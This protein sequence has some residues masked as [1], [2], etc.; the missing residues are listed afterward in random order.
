MVKKF[1]HLT[2]GRCHIIIVARNRSAAERILAALEIP[3][4]VPHSFT[5]EFVSCDASLIQNC[6]DTSKYLLDKLPKINFLVQS[7]GYGSLRK[8]GTNEGL[9]EQLV[10]RYFCRWKFTHDLLPLLRK[11]K[12]D[13]EEARVMSCLGAGLQFKINL[14]DIPMKNAWGYQ[15]CTHSVVYNDY[16]MEVRFVISVA[17][18]PLPDYTYA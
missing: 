11:A 6:R 16:A 15:V 5:R 2:N 13:G 4:N 3:K 18:K 9:D 1:A 8:A 17:M 12:D 14:N 7:Q 10:L